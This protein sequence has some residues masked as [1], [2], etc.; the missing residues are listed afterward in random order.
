MD[1]IKVINCGGEDFAKVNKKIMCGLL[2]QL[3]RKYQLQF[4]GGKADDKIV[5]EWANE[6]VDEEYKI[7]QFDDTKLETCHFYFEII[8]KIAPDTIN[9]EMI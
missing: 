1:G 7:A 3:M 5:L 4:L 9:E 6:L 2:W 8:K